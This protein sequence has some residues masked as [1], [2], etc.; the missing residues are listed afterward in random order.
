MDMNANYTCDSCGEFI[1]IALDPSGGSVQDYVED[2][3]VCCVPNVIRVE[4][5]AEGNAFASARRE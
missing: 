5:D 2:C 1:E 3:P 4:Y